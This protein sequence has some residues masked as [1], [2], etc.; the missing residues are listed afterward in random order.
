MVGSGLPS[1]W[2]GNGQKVK[3]GK[4]HVYKR[5]RCCG[6][7]FMVRVVRQQKRLPREVAVSILGDIQNPHGYIPELP[8]VAAPAVSCGVGLDDLQRP[9]PT[10]AIL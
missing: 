6:F 1:E 8:A 10:S 2:R 7:F 4:F 9:L 3:Y 5:K